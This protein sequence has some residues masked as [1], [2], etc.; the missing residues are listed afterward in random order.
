MQLENEFCKPSAAKFFLKN[1]LNF[2]T[3]IFQPDLCVLYIVSNLGKYFIC[4][5]KCPGSLIYHSKH[6]SPIHATTFPK[7]YPFMPLPPSSLDFPYQIIPK[8]PYYPH[9]LPLPSFSPPS[10][11]LSTI[12]AAQPQRWA[13][14][15]TPPPLRPLPQPLLPVHR[16]H[17]Q[18]PWARPCPP[19]LASPDLIAL[20]REGQISPP[21]RLPPLTSPRRSGRAISCRRL[22][23]LRR[24]INLIVTVVRPRIVPPN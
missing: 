16:Q 11:L 12:H 14:T 15:L 1:L 8:H 17:R 13:S 18:P 9:I 21:P 5:C 2:Y 6:D 4:H 7:Y 20:L 19:V 3:L 22:A 23:R 24:P 10:L